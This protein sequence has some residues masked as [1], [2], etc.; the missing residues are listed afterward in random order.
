[1]QFL[2]RVVAW[3]ILLRTAGVIL[4]VIAGVILGLNGGV[5]P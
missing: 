2:A 3:A 1:M 5:H 4:V